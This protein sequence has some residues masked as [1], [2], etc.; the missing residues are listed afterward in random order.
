MQCKS[1]CEQK[2]KQ[3]NTAKIS[4]ARGYIPTCAKGFFKKNMYPI[5]IDDKNEKKILIDFDSI[6][7]SIEMVFRKQLTTTPYHED[8]ESV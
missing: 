3:S 4:L 1:D 5:R 2:Q 8:N 7:S 6:F